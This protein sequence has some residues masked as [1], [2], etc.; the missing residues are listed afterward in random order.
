MRENLEWLE[1]HDLDEESDEAAKRLGL[2]KG[3]AQALVQ[4]IGD[5]G[6][7]GSLFR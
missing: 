1:D 2:I 3:D 6:M 4:D 7:L 5:E